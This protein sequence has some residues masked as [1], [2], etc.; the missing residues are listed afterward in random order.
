MASISASVYVRLP[1]VRIG[2]EPQNFLSIFPSIVVRYNMGFV[3]E[4]LSVYP[5]LPCSPHPLL[6]SSASTSF[7]FIF[8]FK[9]SRRICVS[10][11][12]VSLEVENQESFK[13]C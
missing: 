7:S 5:S 3:D 13:A 1:G 6:D 2:D 12:S 11:S 4:C 9:L 10:G 8:R